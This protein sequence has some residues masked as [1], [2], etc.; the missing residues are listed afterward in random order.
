MNTTITRVLVAVSMVFFP[1]GVALADSDG[2]KGP[3]EGRGLG[4][5]QHME[6]NFD[7][8]FGHEDQDDEDVG[9]RTTASTT[10]RMKIE[11]RREDRGERREDGR[12]NREERAS[13]TA[14][15]TSASSTHERGR[16]DGPRGIP[17]FLQWLFGLPGTTTIADIRAEIAATSTASTTNNAGLGF[18]A[19]MFGFFHFGQSGD[20]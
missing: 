4:I 9:A 16:G 5:F 3:S 13:S 12:E 2:Q 10:L 20:N 11:D 1:A 14:S 6:S 15:S 19:R 7:F 18:W 8:L 17:F